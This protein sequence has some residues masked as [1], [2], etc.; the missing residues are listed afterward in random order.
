MEKIRRFSQEDLSTAFYQLVKSS[1]KDLK[2]AFYQ[3]I[4][5]LISASDLLLV[6]SYNVSHLGQGEEVHL[7]PGVLGHV[8]AAYLPHYGYLAMMVGV[9]GISFN[10][11]NILVLTHKDT[12]T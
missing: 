6:T 10:M 7:V 9:L 1:Q 8:K 5:Q 11:L 12:L 2:T 3:L 4:T